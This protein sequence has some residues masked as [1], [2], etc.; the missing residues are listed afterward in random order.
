MDKNDG[1]RWFWGTNPLPGHAR[2][3]GGIGGTVGGAGRF[4]CSGDFTSE[5]CLCSARSRQGQA[6]RSAAHAV[7]KSCQE[8]AL[9]I[10]KSGGAVGKERGGLIRPKRIHNF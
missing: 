2:R 9:G 10:Q 6:Q 3:R 4:W 5:L 1:I 8:D 7:T